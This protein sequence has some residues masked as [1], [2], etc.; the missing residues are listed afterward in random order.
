MA[1]TTKSL[2]TIKQNDY[3]ILQNKLKSFDYLE[4]VGFLLASLWG[5]KKQ[6]DELD[7][8][9]KVLGVYLE[10]L[11][12]LTTQIGNLSFVLEAELVL[13]NTENQ[14]NKLSEQSTVTDNLL[15]ILEKIEYIK[16]KQFEYV[17]PPVVEDRLVEL[18]SSVVNQKQL[19]SKTTGLVNILERIT[20]LNSSL[21]NFMVWDGSEE[22]CTAISKMVEDLSYL[23]DKYTKIN[24]L[25]SNVSNVEEA[26]A[27]NAVETTALEQQF[28]ETMPAVC[29]LCNQIIIP[30]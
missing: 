25:I 19:R 8:K 20:M 10:S 15:F 9:I 29:P 6:Y 26:I 28:H 16:N 27:K 14:L 18:E 4:Q 23:V 21:V 12:T 22:V 5:L 13:Q 1:R 24:L 11:T 17:V 2:Q 3:D 30:A 7:K